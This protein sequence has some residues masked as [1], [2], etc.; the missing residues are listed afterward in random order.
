[1]YSSWNDQVILIFNQVTFKRQLWDCEVV[2]TSSYVSVRQDTW[3][4]WLPWLGSTS[5]I[6]ANKDEHRL[7]GLCLLCHMVPQGSNRR[8]PLLAWEPLLQHKGSCKWN[9]SSGT[10]FLLPAESYGPGWVPGCILP[11]VEQSWRNLNSPRGG[12]CSK[13]HLGG[14]G[15]SQQTRVRRVEYWQP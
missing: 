4:P 2:K 12:Y 9:T 7:P 8:L 3:Y 5:A 15:N 11:L 14:R 13:M 10:S 6:Q 1:M